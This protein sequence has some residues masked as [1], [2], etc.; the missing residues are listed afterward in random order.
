MFEGLFQPTHLIVILVI[1]LV[2]FGP[3]KLSEVGGSMGKALRGF[4]KAMSDPT[5][6]EEPNNL[7][8]VKGKDDKTGLSS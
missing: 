2:V 8:I 3:G 1:V 5:D 4:K 7:H 6:A